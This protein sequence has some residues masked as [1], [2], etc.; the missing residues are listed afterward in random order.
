MKIAIMGAG[1]VGAY[2]GGA[3]ARQG[4]DVVLIARGDHGAAMRRNGLSVSSHWG[5]YLVHPRVVLTPEEAGV[6]DLV[7]HCV[8]LYSNSD[9]IPTMRPLVGD[10]TVILT[11]QNGIT[12]G[13][14]LADEIWLGSRI[15]RRDLH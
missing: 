11:V 5:D 10:Q 7:L 1:A 6:V 3:L 13:E 12:G 15:G 9:T 14:S 8:K 4:A 2:Y